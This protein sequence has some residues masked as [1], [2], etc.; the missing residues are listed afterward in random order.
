MI[1][2]LRLKQ[3]REFLGLTQNELALK[4]DVSQSTVAYLEGG[5]L[6]PSDDLLQNICERTG[7]PQSFFEQ[8]EVTEFPYGSLLYRSRTS[9]DASERSRVNRYGQFMFEVAEQLSSKLNYR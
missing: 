5:Y 9:V 6:Q 2:G 3:V 8:V 4:L 7:F 1:N